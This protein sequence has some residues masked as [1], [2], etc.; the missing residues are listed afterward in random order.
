MQPVTWSFTTA[1]PP[2][3]P[4][5]DGPGGPILLVNSSSNPFSKYYAEILRNEG[6]NEF[7]TVDV[8]SLT[9]SSLSGRDVV[10]VANVGLSAAQV[11]ALTTFVNNGGSLIAMRP[12]SQ[13]AGL[14][15]IAPASG[16]VSDGYMRVDTAQEAAAGIAGQTMQFHGTA[17]RYTMSG[18][19]TVATLYSDATTATSNPAVTL[20][21]VGANGGQVA[22]F[23]YD[24]ARSVV[25]TRQ[26]N[27][28]WAGQERDG[29]NPIRSDDQFFGGALTDWVNLAKVAV[30][31]ADEQQ[32]LLANLILT[33]NRHNKPLPRFWYFPKGLKAVV[34]ATGDD[35]G[36]GGTA[37][38]FDQYVAN[39]PAGCSVADWTCLRFSSY[40]FTGTPLSNGQATN[41]DQQGFEVGLHVSTGCANYTPTSIQSDMATQLSDW[42]SKYSSVPAPKTNRT[43]CIAW[44]DWASQPVA[45]VDN[46]I[47]LDTNYYYWPGSWVNDRPGFFTGSGMPMRFAHT[48]GTDDRRL[49]GGDAADRRV[50]PEL[51]RDAGRAAGRRARTATATTA[52]SRP[53]CTPTR[54]RS[55]RTT[56]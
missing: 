52:R 18:A 6:L 49:P 50:Q 9:A 21:S 34:V 38:R 40:I 23:S 24:L 39:S 29:S 44:S 55:S 12:D 2:P 45:A 48:D 42:K 36:N 43:H 5:E 15:G 8:T 25:L 22:A 31:Q 11:T 19:T 4:P 7:S 28:S 17:D 46:G 33:M 54:R 13:L 51:S 37:G 53:T 32:R 26:G 56:S 27:P 16:P 3:P 20:R 41:Y 30:P 1:A 35:H 10:I 47:R 14:L